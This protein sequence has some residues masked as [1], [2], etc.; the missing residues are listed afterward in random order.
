M[1][2][3]IGGRAK[4]DGHV[5]VLI[6]HLVDAGVSILQYVYDTIIFIEHD[7]DKAIDLK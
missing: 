1:L 4:D 3:Y 7:M 6:P 5:R 2:A